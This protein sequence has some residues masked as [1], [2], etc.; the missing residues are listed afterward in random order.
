MNNKAFFKLSYGLY[1]VSSSCDGKDSACIANTFVQVTSEP[2]RVC[3]T[4]NKN[5]YTTSLIENSCVYNVGVLLDDIDMDV[6]RRFGFQSGKDVNKF[7]GIDYEVDCQNIKQIT[8][9]IAAS[10]SVKVIS[11]TDVGTHIM[12]VGDVIDCKVINEGEVLTYANYHNKK[13]GTTPKNAS[14]YQADTSKHGWRCTV[15]GFILEADEL[16]EDFICPVCKQPSSVFEK[17]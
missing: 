11:M 8:E 2:A 14:S 9:G 13:N 5:N 4:L 10:F 6:I 7:D 17:I 16:P 15:C 3:I 12:F 1:V